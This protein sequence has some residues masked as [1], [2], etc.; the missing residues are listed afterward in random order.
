MSKQILIVSQDQVYAQVLRLNLIK[1]L[2]V[3]VVEMG[4]LDDGMAFLAIL[5]SI[6]LIVIKTPGFSEY[7][8]GEFLTYLQEKGIFAPVIILG[9][10]TLPVPKNVKFEKNTKDFKYLALKVAGV[11]GIEFENTKLDE[12]NDFQSIP[13]EFF[14]NINSSSL[15]CDVYIRIKKSENDFQ[16]IKRLHSNDQFTRE[17]I[18]KYQSSGLKEFYISKNHFPDF[19]NYVTDQLIQK[20]SSNELIGFDRLKLSVD[21]FEVTKERIRMLGV[22]E[23]TKTLVDESI[24]SMMKSLSEKNSLAALF[25]MVKSHQLSYAYTHSY[26][27]ALLLHK[28]IE[29]FDWKSPMIKERLSYVAYFHDISL[30]DEKHMMVGSQSELKKLNLTNSDEELVMKHALKS[31]EIL[32]KFDELPAGISTI[33]KEHHG[34]KNGIGFPEELSISLSPLSMVFIVVE[35]FV[36]RFLTISHDPKLEDLIQIFDQLREKYKKSTYKEAF[37][38]L[39]SMTAKSK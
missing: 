26:L 16:F 29:S 18:E 13:I 6:D 37:L 21:V 30:S 8:V 2:N 19:V 23:Y 36:N 12:L 31:A 25:Q 3:E 27:I 9:P 14:F 17:D 35:D 10:M 1:F 7:Q 20:L 32:E 34:S 28:V 38:A 15:G 24:H 4:T 33:V 5:P 39:E 11:I 22:D